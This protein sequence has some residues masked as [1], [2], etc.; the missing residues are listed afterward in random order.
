MFLW[1][2]EVMLKAFDEHMPEMRREWEAAGGKVE[3]AY[4]QADGDFDR[5]RRDGKARQR[6]FFRAGLR[7]GRPGELDLA[8]GDG[9][10]A[11]MRGRKAASPR[12]AKFWRSNPSG[13]IVD[14]PGKLV[15]LLG[16]KDL[17]VVE[18]GGVLLVADKSRAQD[19][20]LVVDRVKKQRPELA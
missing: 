8:R 19:I 17:I 10:R 14:A 3:P 11:C 20:K 5:L 9:R 18:A 13:N 2:A 16:V 7:L 6:R 15:A 12:A 1:R 4:P